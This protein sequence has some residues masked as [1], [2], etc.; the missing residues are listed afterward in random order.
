MYRITMTSRAVLRLPFLRRTS[1]NSYI[2]ARRCLSHKTEKAAEFANSRFFEVS[3]EVRD[4][5]NTGKPV[6]ALETTIYTHGTMHSTYCRKTA[7]LTNARLSI[8]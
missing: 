1:V 8:S 7:S 2:F 3:E 6:V 4:A 5:I